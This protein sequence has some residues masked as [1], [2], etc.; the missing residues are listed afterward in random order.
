VLNV[1]GKERPL[2]PSIGPP[3]QLEEPTCASPKGQEIN[4]RQRSRERRDAMPLVQVKP[5]SSRRAL[6][7]VVTPELHKGEPHWPLTEQQKRGSGRNNYGRITVRHQGGGHK[8]HLRIIDFRRSKDGIAAK[9][10]RLNTTR[11]QRAPRAPALRRRRAPLRGRAQGLDRGTQLMSAQSADQERQRAAAA[12]YPVGTIVH[13]V[14]MMPG[15]AQQL[16]RSAERTCRCSRERLV[17]AAQ[18]ALGRDPQGAHRLPR[19]HWRSRQCEHNLE[20]I[21]KAGACAGAACARPCA[22]WR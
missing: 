13:C 18:A 14:E 2:R 1:R 4:S 20:S 11:P 19:H 7:R 9:V 10:E 12:Q 17:R 3:A 6:V 5:T 15:R 16:A 21:G 22:G 8:H